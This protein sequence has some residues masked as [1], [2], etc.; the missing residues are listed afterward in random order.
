MVGSLD[1]LDSNQPV[2]ISRYVACSALTVVSE[3]CSPAILA[4]YEESL[5]LLLPGGVSSPGSIQHSSG[6]AQ[7]TAESGD[8]DL[9]LG[10]IQP[11]GNSD[12]DDRESRRRRSPGGVTSPG[13]T[14]PWLEGV[15]PIEKVG[16]SS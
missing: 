5:R 9:R 2:S 1:V 16:G 4:K 14:Q 11:G 6:E 15:E 12:V 3:F 13:L 7:R 8:G 10:S